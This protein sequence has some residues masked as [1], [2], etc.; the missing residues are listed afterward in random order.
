MS[1]SFPTNLDTLLNPGPNDLLDNAN[2]SLDHDVQH[3][4]INDAVEALEAKVGVNSSAVV[5]SLDY[6]MANGGAL[7]QS[8]QITTDAIGVNVTDDSQVIALGKGCMVLRLATDYP[9]W[10]RIY[11]SEAAQIA[12]ASRLQT[13]DPAGEHGVLLEV[14]TSESNLSIDLSPGVLCYSLESSPEANLPVSVTNLGTQEVNVT[15]TATF[16]PFEG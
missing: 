7:R 8:A 15:I 14:I 2:P 5:G 6:R 11:S 13:V 12:D 1:T 16:I 10:V 4:N 3:T 9:A